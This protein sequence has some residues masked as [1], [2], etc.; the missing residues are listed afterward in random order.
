[1]Q[2]LARLAKGVCRLNMLLG[3]STSSDQGREHEAG[4]PVL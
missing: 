4:K 3:F 2:R 1:M